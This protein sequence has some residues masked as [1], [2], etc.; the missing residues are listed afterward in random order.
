[1]NTKS[2]SYNV[3]SFL[4]RQREQSNR[5]GPCVRKR[6]QTRVHGDFVNRQ[7]KGDQGNGWK[8]NDTIALNFM[9]DLGGPLLDIS[10]PANGFHRQSSL[11]LLDVRFD[12][13]HANYGY[14][15]VDNFYGPSIDPSLRGSS[16]DN[17]DIPFIGSWLVRASVPEPG[18]WTL[19]LSGLASAAFLS[20][21]RRSKL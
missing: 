2:K 4:N 10:S 20:L 13:G 3:L 17:A 21:Y 15:A 12:L 19:C 5:Q 6:P 1:M 8:Q 16:L 18:A 14:I 9:N 11:S 7:H